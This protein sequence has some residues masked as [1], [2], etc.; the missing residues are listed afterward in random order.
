MRRLDAGKQLAE[1]GANDVL[2]PGPQTIRPARRNVVQHGGCA[3]MHGG[4]Q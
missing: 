3:L 1:V 4:E 2:E